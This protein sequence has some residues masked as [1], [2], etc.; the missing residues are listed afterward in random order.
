MTNFDTANARISG[1]STFLGG[2]SLIALLLSINILSSRARDL[3]PVTAGAETATIFL[4][5]SATILFLLSTVLLVSP[6]TDANRAVEDSVKRARSMIGTGAVFIFLGVGSLVTVAF[7]ETTQAYL[8]GAGA[9]G[10]AVIFA[11][12]RARIGRPG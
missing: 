1:F 8:Y 10:G 6:Y 9:V 12:V 2:L 11:I 4:F 3:T 7:G 5:L